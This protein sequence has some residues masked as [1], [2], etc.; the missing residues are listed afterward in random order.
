MKLSWYKRIIKE[1][2]SGARLGSSD[3]NEYMKIKREKD[4][5]KETLSEKY[6]SKLMYE[7]NLVDRLIEK[8]EN[9]D[10]QSQS[11]GKSPQVS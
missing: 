10:T 7:S 2:F 1:Q 6:N 4:R 3:F 5:M 9:M 11:G 8:T